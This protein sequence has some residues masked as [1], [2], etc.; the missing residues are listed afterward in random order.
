[1]APPSA[2]AMASHRVVRKESSRRSL[3]RASST[4][5][6]EAIRIAVLSQ[7]IAGSSTGTQSEPVRRTSSAEVNATKSMLTVASTAA[8][9]MG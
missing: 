8:R 1:M 9:P 2:P 7:T 6:L 3:V 5:A 4:A